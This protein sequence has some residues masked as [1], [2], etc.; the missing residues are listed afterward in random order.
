MS[1]TKKWL[2]TFAL[3][4]LV[5][6]VAL[7]RSHVTPSPAV[8]ATS[9]LAGLPQSNGA[10]FDRADGPRPFSF[11]ADFGP[12][13]NFQT[14]WWYYT[15]NLTTDSGRHFGF[16]LTFFR[17]GLI[18]PSLQ[19]Q[20]ASDWAANQVYM[21]HFALT[22]VAGDQFHA[23]ERLE[24][25][26]E[27]LA[28]AQSL[29]AYQVWI[30]DWRVSASGKDSYQLNASDAGVSILLNLVDTKGP[31]LEGDQ[32]YSQ[33]GSDPGN[34]SY[35]FSQTRLAT[36][37]TIAIDGQ[38]YQ[39]KGASWM[40][41]EFSTSALSSNEVG[42]DWFAIHLDGGTD[43]MLY[44]IRSPAGAAVWSNGTLVSADGTKQSLASE[45]FTIKVDSKWK[46]PHSHAVYPSSW[47]IEIPSEHLILQIAPYLPDQELNLS[48][49][50][51]EGAV[52]ISGSRSGQEISGQGYVELT[53]YANPM[54]G[55]F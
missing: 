23:F 8:Q 43:L 17:R 7:F 38:T 50:Y 40:D 39:V 3:V 15:G 53:G 9:P 14:E 6:A 4:I 37:G 51:W 13:P 2:S 22:D 16:E 24:R 47:T 33:K 42:W 5:L 27:G 1:R 36:N 30:D 44:Q 54:N 18:P 55:Q 46:S 21:G 11:P 49:T 52:K 45:D 26:A 31:I 10:G 29:P 12:H 48:F 28:G 20:R 34:A 19:T 35:Y 25:G 41:H 32:G